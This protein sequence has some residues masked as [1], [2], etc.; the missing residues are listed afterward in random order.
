MFPEHNTGNSLLLA[1]ARALVAPA[2]LP[3]HM[4]FDESLPA[5]QLDDHAAGGSLRRSG[6]Q[7][8]QR[9]TGSAELGRSL[10]ARQASGSRLQAPA[11]V[12]VPER[13]RVLVSPVPRQ[14]C[15]LWRLR[16]VDA[17]TFSVVFS[18]YHIHCKELSQKPKRIRSL[19]RA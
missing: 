12:D 8:G 19:E 5:R 15:L 4:E 11:R 14:A 16:A 9:F 13:S 18:V 6:V 3:G 2:L 7:A 1:C 10:R 17:A